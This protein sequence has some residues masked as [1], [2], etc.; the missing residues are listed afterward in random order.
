M[1]AVVA[2]KPQAKQPPRIENRKVPTRG[3]N[4]AVRDREYL[5]PEEAERMIRAAGKAGRHG[6]RDA[7]LLLVAYRHGL[8]V[9]ELVSLKWGQVDLKQARLHVSRLKN[10]TPAVHPIQGRTLRVLRPLAKDGGEF[11]FMSERG[12]PLTADAVR[13]IVQ[14]AGKLAG[15]P[16]PVHPHMLRH[17]CGFY[18]ANAG[19]DTRTIQDYLGHKNI[20]HTVRYTQLSAGK[21][22]NLWKD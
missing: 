20:Q 9:S 10:G 17:G 4:A 8:R 15:L 7:A 2:L 6:A 16:F 11:V 1:G 19:T 3:T 21:F 18:L 12:A 14:R 5:T 22:K 13:K